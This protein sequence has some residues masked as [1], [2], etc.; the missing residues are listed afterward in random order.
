M[1]TISSLLKSIEVADVGTSAFV[2]AILL[3]MATWLY[4]YT[5][6]SKEEKNAKPLER[7]PSALPLLRN[8]LDLLRN[9]H[10]IHRW[11]SEQSCKLEGRPCKMG[12]F[13]RTDRIILSNPLVVEDVYKKQF[14]N[15][16]KTS[17]GKE[18]L[19]ELM[20]FS[21]QTGIN[22]FFNVKQRVTS[23]LLEN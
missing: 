3:K 22:G 10:D 20:A 8:T 2:T 23:S 21:R 19:R 18:F 12:A 4:T 15:F 17:E 13:N 11:V 5:I 16:Q 7:P 1:L 14:E 6:M 9:M